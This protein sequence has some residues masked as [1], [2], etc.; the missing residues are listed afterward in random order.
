MGVFEPKW[1]DLRFIEDS[2]SAT[3]LE[4]LV[5]KVWYKNKEYRFRAPK[6]FTTD[7]ASIPHWAWPIIGPPMR[8]DY[9]KSAIIHDF[10]YRINGCSR[11]FADDIFY[12]GMKDCGVPTWKAYA[13]FLAVRVGGWI[14]WN[15]Y[16]R[17]DGLRKEEG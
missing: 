11:K 16:R 7:G 9:L 1:A 13:M 15:K 17:Q 5:Y 12:L 10:L 6:G 2:D 8:E 4:P 3:L 14:G